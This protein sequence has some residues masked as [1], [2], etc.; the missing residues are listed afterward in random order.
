MGNRR[1][2]AMRQAQP[3]GAPAGQ[4]KPATEEEA[5]EL[6]AQ[7]EVRA[8]EMAAHRNKL[9]ARRDERVNAL[10]AEKGIKRPT[11]EEAMETQIASDYNTMKMERIKRL[12]NAEARKRFFADYPEES[13]AVL[14]P[15]EDTK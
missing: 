14:E 5:I 9:V 4:Q 6:S 8:I 3:S 10:L 1:S 2:K 11:D 13:G 12:A 15:I 7:Q